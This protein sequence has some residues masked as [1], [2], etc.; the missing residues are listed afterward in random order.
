MFRPV[1]GKPLNRTYFEYGC[2]VGR[3]FCPE[4]SVQIHFVKLV[5]FVK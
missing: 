3:A 5:Y 2:H 4:F 1:N